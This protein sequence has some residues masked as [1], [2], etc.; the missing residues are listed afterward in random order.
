M[1][2]EALYDDG[3]ISLITPVKL[4][5]R[6]VQVTVTVADSELE[7]MPADDTPDGLDDA[8]RRLVASLDAIRHAPLPVASDVPESSPKQLD[9]IDAFA[10]RAN[11]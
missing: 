2:L 6:R 7:S 1:Q 3:R 5:H 11:R 9:R 4:R 8:A 10:M